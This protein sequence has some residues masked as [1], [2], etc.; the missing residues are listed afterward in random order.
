MGTAG[1]AGDG[2]AECK[3]QMQNG[4]PQCNDCKAQ[5]M[6]APSGPA[7]LLVADGEGAF[8]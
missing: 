2:D 5:Q 3:E 4:M 6:Q 8:Q 1:T 7:Q